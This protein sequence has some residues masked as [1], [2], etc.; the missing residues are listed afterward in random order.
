MRFG[1][2][3][4][5]FHHNPW[6][7]DDSFTYEDGE[8]AIMAVVDGLGHSQKAAHAARVAVAR[9]GECTALSLEEMLCSV[10]DAL[11]DTV[12]GALGIAVLYRGRASLQVCGIGNIAL[13]LATPARLY[14]FVGQPGIAGER[15]TPFR[16]IS[17][18]Y[19]PGD[20]VV[21]YSDG[22]RSAFSAHDLVHIL[23]PDPARIARRILNGYARPHDDALVLVGC[24]MEETKNPV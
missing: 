10:E 2:A 21:M 17:F 24:E 19:Q 8:R 15:Q 5:S 13:Q 14:R 1:V 16:P 23:R 22:I 6:C 9:L 18:P 20:V 11:K 3:V 12:G 4:P 7:G